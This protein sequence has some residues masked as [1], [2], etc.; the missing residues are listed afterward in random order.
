MCILNAMP[1]NKIPQSINSPSD[2]GPKL[3]DSP[4]DTGPK[5]VNKITTL[6]AANMALPTTLRGDISESSHTEPV[7]VEDAQNKYDTSLTSLEEIIKKLDISEEERKKLPSIEEIKESFSRGCRAWHHNNLY[8]SLIS[9]FDIGNRMKLPD[10][11]THAVFKMN[12]QELIT[13]E[14]LKVVSDSSEKLRHNFDFEKFFECQSMVDSAFQGSINIEIDDKS[15]SSGTH[16]QE[17]FHF[18][19]LLEVDISNSLDISTIKLDE[20]MQKFSMSEH[21]KERLF[22]E[23]RCYRRLGNAICFICSRV[24]IEH[25]ME[26][27]AKATHVIFKID[28]RQAI[29]WNIIEVHEQRTRKNF[30]RFLE[31]ANKNK[32]FQAILGVQ[33]I[34]LV[35]DASGTIKGD[36]AKVKDAASLSKLSIAD[37]PQSS[38]AKRSKSSSA[39]KPESSGTHRQELF[40]FKALPKADIS[41]S[42]DISTIKLDEMMQKFNMQ[43]YIP[44]ILFNTGRCYAHLNHYM[45][46]VFSRYYIRR[47]MQLT[48]ESNH[49]IFKIDYNKAKQFNIVEF[50]EENKKMQNFK[51]F[52]DLA[53]DS[54]EFQQILDVQ[55]IKLVDDQASIVKDK[56]SS[57][58]LTIPGRPQSSGADRVKSFDLEA[59][60]DTINSDH[61]FTMKLGAMIQKLRMSKS[62][63]A[64]LISTGKCYTYLDHDIYFVLSRDFIL[65]QIQ[66]PEEASY[67]VF[68]IKANQAYRFNIIKFLNAM[69]TFV[70]QDLV[71][72]LIVAQN[73]EFQ[74][75]VDVQLIKLVDD[76]TRKTQRASKKSGR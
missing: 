23:G 47:Q 74:Q 48:G 31:F 57:S 15:E 6:Q 3:F 39:D 25:Q 7:I 42:L 35:D 37:R 59:L 36:K 27:P 44:E 66:L 54:P 73:P 49:V 50:S 69:E 32:A 5:S 76:K 1:G 75:I 64:I 24:D 12:Y 58:E 53:I 72:K 71:L 62:T 29:E 67:V 60:V 33:V 68:K 56:A 26:L 51:L 55:V 22:T 61:I 14:V 34:K 8:I 21:I 11:A 18:K 43:K 63:K 19:P 20:M 16:R 28:L 9:K 38:G 13:H 46:F 41:N 52:L 30:E 45:Y 4:S 40:H 65:D 2:T 70:D 17:L 10:Q